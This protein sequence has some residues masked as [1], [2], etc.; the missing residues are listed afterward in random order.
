MYV[1]KRLDTRVTPCGERLETQQEAKFA[2]RRMNHALEFELLVIDKHDIG[3]EVA[4]GVGHAFALPLPH[5]KAT[6]FPVSVHRSSVRAPHPI[7]IVDKSGGRR[8]RRSHVFRKGA[9][10][11]EG[12]ALLLSPFKARLMVSG[13]MALGSLAR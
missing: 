10:A 12:I 13:H 1:C 7:P 6:S 2:S 4:S 11:G 8:L 5:W 3:S 9:S